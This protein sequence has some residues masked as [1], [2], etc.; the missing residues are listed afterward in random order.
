MLMTGCGLEGPIP[1][2]PKRDAPAAANQSP[3]QKPAATGKAAPEKVAGHGFGREKS[4]A[5]TKPGTVREKA[6]VG[7][8]ERG[9]GYG[10]DPITAAIKARWSAEERIVFDKI[11]HDLDIYK[12]DKGQF[13]RDFQEFKKEI[14]SPSNLKLPPLPTGDSYS[15]DPIGGELL[16]E[17]SK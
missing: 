16:V 1:S 8:G 3:E 5:E 12:A 17:H 10:G 4:T 7:V 13:P 6:A 15:Y 11:R 14:L 9:R 2:P